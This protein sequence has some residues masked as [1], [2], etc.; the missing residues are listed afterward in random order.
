M[1]RA[2]KYAAAILLLVGLWRIVH[3]TGEIGTDLLFGWIGFLQR[4]LPHV[5][6]RRD[7]LLTFALG[8]VGVTLVA[9]G[10]L[11]WIS[12]QIQSR[13]PQPHIA[14]RVR[15]TVMLV[16]MVVALFVAGISMIGV[17]H[18][19]AWLATSNDPLFGRHVYNRFVDHPFSM[20]WV[21]LA[22]DNTAVSRG[23]PNRAVTDADGAPQS[24][25]LYILPYLG[26]GYLPDGVDFSLPWDH[27]DNEDEFKRLVPEL[28]NPTL[29]NAPVRDRDG[30][31]LNHYAGNRNLFDR[32]EPLVWADLTEK[33][34]LLMIGEVNSA[35]IAWGHPDNSRDPS[36]GLNTSEGFGGPFG[37][38]GVHF[39][40]ADG[41][42]RVI[43]ND[44][45][46]S[47]LRALSEL[48]PRA[49]GTTVTAVPPGGP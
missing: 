18:Q 49:G 46:P 43:A 7:G 6:L 21:G 4:T 36:T 3:P 37:S 39:V 19:T 47:V 41:S 38:A 15:S 26:G 23:F 8:L 1:L 13:R 22:I 33:S 40:M 48:G 31:G 10:L 45:D 12:Q 24:W 32:Q 35:L 28:I 14:W 42:V 34:N 11:R 27:P 9:H 5:T 30:F 17:T 20:R 16:G 2:V 29:R 25:V 44:V